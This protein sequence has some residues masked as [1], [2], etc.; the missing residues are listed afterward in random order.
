MQ[1]RRMV[2]PAAAAVIVVGGGAVALAASGATSPSSTVY[3]GCEGTSNHREIIDVYSAKTPACPSGDWAITFDQAGAQGPAGPAGPAGPS[4]VVSTTNTNLVTTPVSVA[5]GGTFSTRKTLV[6]TVTLAAGTYLIDVNAMAAPNEVT[7]GDVYPSLFIYNGAQKSDFS[8]DLF[9]V[10]S[11]ALETPNS[12]EVTDGDVID[13]Y[14]SGDAE[15]TVPAG[16]ETLDV[17]AFGYDSD[18]GEGSFTLNTAVVT[19]TALQTGS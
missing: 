2:V 8:N 14:Y 19:A 6:G 15:I 5:T 12:A 17:Y 18:A 9:N 7:T 3:H 10:G 13:S 16:G 4:G 1:F 11:G